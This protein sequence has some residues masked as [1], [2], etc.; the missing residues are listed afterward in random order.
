MGKKGQ[1]PGTG[2]PRKD[3][4]D[5]GY[6]TRN[7]VT[8]LYPESAKEGWRDIVREWC[9]QAF[10][11]PL[12]DRDAN[13]DG[14]Q[15]K[16]HWHLMVMMDG[17]KSRGRMEKAFSEI[18]G[19]G[20][21]PCNSARGYARYLCHLDN[22]EKTQYNVE[23]VECFGGADYL[24]LIQLETDKIKIVKEMQEYCVDNGVTN[25]AEFMLYCK[26]ERETWY[27]S[28]C[29]STSNLMLRFLKSLEDRETG[30]A[31]RKAAAAKAQAEAEAAEMK[32]QIREWEQRRQKIR[33]QIRLAVRN[34]FAVDTELKAA[35]FPY[36]IE[37]DNNDV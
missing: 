23:D 31:R 29:T 28:L 10:V 3:S 22:P 24:G 6:K 9:C 36:G 17:P 5:G 1:A 12:H 25:F 19:V 7:W 33:E 32:K 18:G 34:G 26:D 14:E 15:K 37:R 35:F 11:S 21:Q 13:P 30:A 16:A 2:R 27:R 20:C 8:V 4:P